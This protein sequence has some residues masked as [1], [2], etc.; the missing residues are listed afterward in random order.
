[1]D[2]KTTDSNP[3]ILVCIAA[4]A[5]HRNHPNIQLPRAAPSIEQPSLSV[6][7]STA[8]AA[9]LSLRRLA[10]LCLLLSVL[11]R[12]PPLGLARRLR[13]SLQQHKVLWQRAQQRQRNP[14]WHPGQLG[15]AATCQQAAGRQVVKAVL[16]RILGL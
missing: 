6:S 12:L 14:Q 2:S 13:R 7:A 4:S 8:S 10:L 9:S 11:C 15:R 3:C 5:P 16:N 1:M